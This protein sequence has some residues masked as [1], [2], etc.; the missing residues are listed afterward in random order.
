MDVPDE[1]VIRN[2]CVTVYAD[3][4]FVNGIP[5]LIMH[6]QKLYLLTAKYLPGWTAKH[7]VKHLIIVENIYKK[8]GFKIQT[9]LIYNESNKVAH[10]IP[11]LIIKTATAQ[12]HVAEVEQK[13]GLFKSK[14]KA[15][16]P[17]SPSNKFPR[18]CWSTSSIFPPC[19]ST[20]G[21]Q[22]LGSDRR[23]PR[24]LITGTKLGMTHTNMMRPHTSPAICLGTCG[25]I[26]VSI[27][28]LNLETEKVQVQSIQ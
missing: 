14:V 4:M 22:N 12:K 20:H 18:S 19:G 23:S 24:E 25:N 13:N 5:F 7:I 9:L 16:L 1:F 8:G 27:Y 21:I 2:R 28:F 26:Q 6:G 17:L 15:S 3:I 11:H 10:E